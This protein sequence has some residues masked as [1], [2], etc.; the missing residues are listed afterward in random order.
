MPST[1]Q[2]STDFDVV[3]VGAGI[4][5][6]Y[7]LHRLRDQLGLSVRGYEAGGDVGGTWYWNRYPGARCDVE[8]AY[9]SYSFSAELENEWE[10]SRRYPEQPEI[11][12]YLNH[13]AD[14]F[15]LRRDFRFDT[16][17]DAV[18]YLDNTHRWR[19]RTNQAEEVTARFLVSAVGCLSTPNIPHFPGIGS[20]TGDQ[21]HTGEWPH[22]GI[23]LSGKRVGVVGTGSSGIQVI[24]RIAE[25]VDELIVFQRTPNFTIPAGDA[26]LDGAEL[27]DIK[28]DYPNIR[29]RARNSFGGMD[30]TPATESALEVT[31]ARR[32]GVYQN[33]WERGGFHFLFS[34]FNDLLTDG[35]ANDT[36]AEFIRHKIRKIVRDPEVAE[37]LCPTDHPYGTKRPPVDTE[38]YETF[39]RENVALVDVRRS[40]I[41]EI[42]ATGIE[43]EDAK[44]T[45]DSIV[46]ATGFDA[47]TGALLD[48][49]IRGKGGR[50]LPRVWQD[51]ARSYLG[52]Q[53][54]G[55]PN[56]FTITGPGSP[57]VLSNMMVSIEQHVE[58]IADCIEYLREC[59]LT[60]IEARADAESAWME[61]VEEVAD[62]TLYPLADSWYMGANI[63]GKKRAFLPYAGGVGTYREICA[64]VAA[65]EY[66]GFELGA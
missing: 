22:E 43:T 37:K 10:W 28:S 12:R 11:L 35:A 18:S 5:G 6:L 59:D 38:Y 62:A 15:Q 51:G 46:F 26:P 49:D 34:T 30:F 60:R 52:L 41:Q 61:H 66:A 27:R 50:K 17:V 3:V 2:R 42:T 25:D 56:L 54:A 9:Y 7:M 55:F 32:Q 1:C 57:S 47:M 23:D 53:I 4:S 21:L 45:L 63:D 20:F 33:S 24:P 58:W 29:Q 44:Y 39:N 19:I 64:D 14:R 65:R 13:V 36:A 48:M 8:S 40:P 31:E 16:R